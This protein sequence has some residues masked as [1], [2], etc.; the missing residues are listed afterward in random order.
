MMKPALFLR[1]GAVLT[2]IHAVLGATISLAAEAVLFWQLGPLAKTDARRLRPMLATLLVAYAALAVNSY[3]Y[4]FL[5]P[6]IAE[7]FIATCLGLAIV[8]A[9][10]QS[11]SLCPDDAAGLI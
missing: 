8:T 5:W 7:I 10:S 3:A 9:K 1:I 11:S 6:V 2:F 4:F